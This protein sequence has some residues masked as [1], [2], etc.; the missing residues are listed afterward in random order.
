[1]ATRFRAEYIIHMP[2]SGLYWMMVGHI[3]SH[4]VTLDLPRTLT[5]FYFVSADDILRCVAGAPV[6]RLLLLLCTCVNA[7]SRNI[8]DNNWYT[9]SCAMLQ[10]AISTFPLSEWNVGCEMQLPLLSEFLPC[11]YPVGHL[12][13]PVLEPYPNP[14]Q[15]LPGILEGWSTGVCVVSLSAQRR[16]YCDSFPAWTHADFK[17]VKVMLVTDS[18]GF[19]LCNKSS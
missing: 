9:E 1:M 10:G 11:L 19:V 2:S 4:P 12:K 17:D 16:C 18:Q 13:R 3:Y 5:A 6:W 7:I 15:I 8:S 14:I